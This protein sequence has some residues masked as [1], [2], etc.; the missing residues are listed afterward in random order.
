MKEMSSTLPDLTFLCAHIGLNG[1]T[2]TPCLMLLETK[3]NLTS[4]EFASVI[5]GIQPS[6]SIDSWTT[7]GMGV[8]LT[9]HPKRKLIVEGSCYFSTHTITFNIGIF[10]VATTGD[11][12]P[13]DAAPSTLASYDDRECDLMPVTISCEIL[14]WDDYVFD[15]EVACGTSFAADTALTVD[16]A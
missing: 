5:L 11:H 7:Q 9:K 10:G 2:L 14:A 15:A 12:T 4:Y 8:S 16:Q 1:R 3:V 13:L 6:M